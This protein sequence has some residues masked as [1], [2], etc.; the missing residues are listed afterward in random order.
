MK[1]AQIMRPILTLALAIVLSAA[2][3]FAAGREKKYFTGKVVGV[4]DGDTLTLLVEE[5]HF[6]IRLAGI[7]APERGQPY[8]R[9]ARQAL[10]KKVLG[11][12]VRVLQIKIHVLVRGR[13][14]YKR[15]LGVVYLGRVCVNTELV[16]EG[17]AWYYRRYFN[18]DSK[19]LAQAEEAAKKAKAG[20]WADPNPVAPWQY[21][22]KTRST[23]LQPKKADRPKPARPRRVYRPAEKQLR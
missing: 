6:K 19:Y 23:A 12:E 3:V 2:T 22:R 21:G 7:D 11:K 8:G 17:W 20:L 1:G 16:K 10:S 18:S 13:V 9:K 14:L 5:T 15:T 4:T